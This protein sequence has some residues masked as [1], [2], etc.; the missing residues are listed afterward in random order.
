MCSIGLHVTIRFLG[1]TIGMF[2]SYQEIYTDTIVNA[3]VRSV[4][5]SLITIIVSTMVS[6]N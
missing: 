5:P 4:S 1:E 3:E 2:S 6:N